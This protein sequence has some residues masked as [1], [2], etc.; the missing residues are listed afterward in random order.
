MIR[1]YLP[2]FIPFAIVMLVPAL[3]S[4]QE[5]VTPMMTT[6]LPRLRSLPSADTDV[7]R[8]DEF[9][10]DGSAIYLGAGIGGLPTIGER[11]MSWRLLVVLPVHDYVSFEGGGSGVHFQ[12]SDHHGDEKTASGLSL[13]AGLRITAPADSVIRPYGALRLQ[14]VHY[15]PDPWGEHEGYGGSEDHSSHHRWG[16]AL[17]VGFDIGLFGPS[18]RW[19][20]GVDAETMLLT[21]P[22]ANVAIS[23][24]AT[25]GVGW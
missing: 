7:P 20:A 3:A 15:W 9:V 11:A 25:I 14:H 8:P 22:G 5:A 10:F 4:A 12:A 24:L 23:T 2:V 6:A 1:A 13:V 16:G 18:S 19:R 21:G 17:A